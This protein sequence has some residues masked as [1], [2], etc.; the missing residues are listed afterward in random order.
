MLGSQLSFATLHRTVTPTAAKGVATVPTVANE[1]FSHG[2]V[3]ACDPSQQSQ[4]K[5]FHIVLKGLA[6]PYNSRKCLVFKIKKN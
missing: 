2:F 6:T 3:G 4:M 5:S 1:E